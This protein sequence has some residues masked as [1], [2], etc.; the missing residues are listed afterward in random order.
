MSKIFKTPVSLDILFNLLNEICLFK[1]DTYVIDPTSF[2]KMIY[3]NL[4][5][6][7]IKKLMEYY[8]PQKQDLL[9][10][11]ASYY[12]FINIIKQICKYHGLIIKSKIVYANSTKHNI[13]F[14]NIDS[15]H[16]RVI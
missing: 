7:F 9:L 8:L 10:K 14:L 12:N 1:E 4:Y 11:H 5:E 3:M 16:T 6:P 15:L 13:Y 2:N